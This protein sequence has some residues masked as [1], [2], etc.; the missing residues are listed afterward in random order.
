MKL[1]IEGLLDSSDILNES[2]T[3]HDSIKSW[4]H[5]LSSSKSKLQRKQI[6][7]KYPE[8]INFYEISQV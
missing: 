1:H 5:P 3:F 8:N 7:N 6:E 4:F 2:N